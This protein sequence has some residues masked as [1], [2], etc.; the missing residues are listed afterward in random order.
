[1]ARVA[2]Q[3]V[4]GEGGLD[5]EVRGERPHLPR[6][7]DEQDVTA[8]GNQLE[9]EVEREGRGARAAGHPPHREDAG[10]PRGGGDLDGGAIEGAKEVALLPGQEDDLAGPGT[11]GGE[12]PL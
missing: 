5:V 4:N 12:Q 11:L 1:P 2:E 7:F 8:C 3:V 9:G 6:E 10:L